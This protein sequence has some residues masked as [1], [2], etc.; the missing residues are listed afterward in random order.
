M[1][2]TTQEVAGEGTESEPCEQLT[3]EIRW[4]NVRETPN[5]PTCNG[6][7]SKPATRTVSFY[8]NHQSERF[9]DCHVCPDC[10]KFIDK[11]LMYKVLIE[12]N[13][14][15]RQTVKE[16]HDSLAFLNAIV[17]LGKSPLLR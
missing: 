1:N 6:C 2:S 15:M 13:K 8:V 16:C 9:T 17:V 12:R 7:Q 14:M 11:D 3:F 10:L 4:S 5:R